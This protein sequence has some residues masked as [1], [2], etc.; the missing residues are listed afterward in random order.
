MYSR[1]LILAP[2]PPPWL[3]DPGLGLG[4]VDVGV[5]GP[6]LVAVGGRPGVQPPRAPILVVLG[7]LLGPDLVGVGGLP[8]VLPPLAPFLVVL[9]ALLGPGLVRVG[10]LGPGR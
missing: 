1:P 10:L 8:C 9:G 5:L 7:A 6:D 2:P 3:F 4:L